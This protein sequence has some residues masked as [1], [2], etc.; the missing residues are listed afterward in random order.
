MTTRQNPYVMLA[1]TC[2]LFA[3]VQCAMAVANDR[4]HETWVF[5][6]TAAV[7]VPV[8]G[9]TLA[10]RALSRGYSWAWGGL[11]VVGLAGLVAVYLLPNRADARMTRGFP[12]EPDEL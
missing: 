1:A 10:R 2:Q 12:I 6:W 3:L 5:G 7:L 8:V 4:P 11:A 9:I